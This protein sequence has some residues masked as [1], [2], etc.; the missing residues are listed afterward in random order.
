MSV[1][2][3]IVYIGV[4]A[5]CMVLV[6]KPHLFIHLQKNPFNSGLIQFLHL[7]SIA[8]IVDALHILGEQR[9]AGSKNGDRG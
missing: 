2:S 5:S 9:K 8:G 4:N 1:E 3:I 7:G 6:S